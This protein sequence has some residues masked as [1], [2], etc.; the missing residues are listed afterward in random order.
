MRRVLATLPLLLLL[1]TAQQAKAWNADGHQIV[2]AI[3]D[4]MLSANAKTK[5]ASILGVDLRTAAPW[6]DCVKSVHRQDDG[7]FKYVV[8]EAFE[9]PCTPFKDARGL[10]EAYVGRNFV[11]CSYTVHRKENGQDFDEEMGCHD[12]YHFDDISILRDRFDRYFQGTNEHDIVAAI[13]A[14]IAVLQ[15]RPSPPP[16]RIATKAEALFL[17]SHLIGDLHQPLHVGAVY[18][19]LQ[20]QQVGVG[21][22]ADQLPCRASP[23]PVAGGAADRKRQRSDRELVVRLGERYDQGRATSV[24]WRQLCQGAAE[25]RSSERGLVYHLS[26]SRG[27]CGCPRSDQA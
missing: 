3:A 5:V 20:G 7:T 2:G 8:E 24:C 25:C 12:T 22:A 10:M 17:L 18:L 16:F 27:L 4:A 13:N 1:L 21:C 19:D 15:D 9:A 14:A 11:Q 6:L 26:R 23:R